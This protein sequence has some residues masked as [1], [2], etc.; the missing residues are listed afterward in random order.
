MH[1]A[2]PSAATAAPLATGDLCRLLGHPA[3]PGTTSTSM[4]ACRDQNQGCTTGRAAPPSGLVNTPLRPARAAPREDVRIVGRTYERSPQSGAAPNASISA[5]TSPSS[6]AR[7]SAELRSTS[8][9]PCHAGGSAVACATALPLEAKY[10]H[11]ASSKSR[12]TM[13]FNIAGVASTAAAATEPST[14]PRWAP[15]RTTGRYSSV[16]ACVTARFS[17]CFRFASTPCTC[18][19]LTLLT[20]RLGYLRKRCS[21]K[22][23][24]KRLACSCEVKL[25][26]AYPTLLLL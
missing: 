8:G 1:S 16:L 24:Q 4:A 3:Q 18:A 23:A 14:S 17:K 11:K 25:M 22:A 13:C 26:K 6:T 21:A 2:A 20:L 7:S 19:T 15:R 9:S 10:A 12:R 5:S